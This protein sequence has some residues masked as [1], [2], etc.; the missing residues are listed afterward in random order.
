MEGVNDAP[1]WG[2]TPFLEIVIEVKRSPFAGDGILNDM[3]RLHELIRLA[4]LA[5]TTVRGWLFVISESGRPE[6]FVTE[7][8]S[9]QKGP[10]QIQGAEGEGW[11]VVR[12]TCKASAR[13][14]GVE[15][16]ETAHYACLIEIFTH[17]PT[18]ADVEQLAD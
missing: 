1:I 5:G 17:K 4:Q 8:G 10:N 9:S 18:A 13:F 2:K 14:E 11:Y 6:Q 7:H 15:R 3:K 16:V 12:K